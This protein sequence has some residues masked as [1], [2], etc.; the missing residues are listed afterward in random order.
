MQSTAPVALFANTATEPVGIP[1]AGIAWGTNS[2]SE[3][4]LVAGQMAFPW[5]SMPVAY[6]YVQVVGAALSCTA[7]AALMGETGPCAHK[8]L[9]TSTKIISSRFF[10]FISTP[11]CLH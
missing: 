6:P 7:V 3:S 5:L 2:M 8:Q 4:A 9:E 10:I 11:Q 1:V